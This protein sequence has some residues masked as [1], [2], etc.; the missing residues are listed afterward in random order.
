MLSTYFETILKHFNY[1]K[2]YIPV[3]WLD[4]FQLVVILLI[5]VY[6][7]YFFVKN[8]QAEKLI[9]GVFIFV[10]SVWVFS[11]ILIRLNMPILGVFLKSIIAIIVLSFLFVFQPELRRFLSYIGQV[12]F[13]NKKT[14][15]P[16]NKNKIDVVKEV[17]EAVKYLK[18]SRMGALIVFQPHLNDTTFSDVGTQLNADVSCELLLTIFHTNTPLHDGAVII[19]NTKILTAGA[20]LPLTED[21]KLSWKYGTRH[22]AAIGMSEVSDSACLVVSEETGDVSIAMDGILKKFDDPTVLKDELE[23]LLGYKEYNAEKDKESNL[24]DF[25]INSVKDKKNSGR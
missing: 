1:M 12:H 3:T 18:K 14:V 6:V 23:T 7:Y 15:V 20:L 24:F 10:S 11:E 16:T 19:H 17:I 13:F 25:L 9:R 4:V 21:P 2:N 8:T 22:R 5:I